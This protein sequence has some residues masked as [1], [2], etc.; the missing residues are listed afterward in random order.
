MADPIAAAVDAMLQKMRTHFEEEC[1]TAAGYS[2]SNVATMPMTADRMSRL[3]KNLTPAPA[4]PSLHCVAS[5][6]WRTR[7][8]WDADVTPTDRWRMWCS[9]SATDQRLERNPVHDAMTS[10][11]LRMR[12]PRWNGPDTDVIY[13]KG[14]RAYHAAL[15]AMRSGLSQKHSG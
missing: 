10:D 12:V 8:M 6:L 3:A 7:H 11:Y 1:L 15:D 9:H 2:S 5:Y 4:P 14:E 13:C